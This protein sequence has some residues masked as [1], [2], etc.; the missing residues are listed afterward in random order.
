MQQRTIQINSPPILHHSHAALSAGSLALHLLADLDVDVE[1]LR[2]A[3]I[4]ADGFALVQFALTVI[5][6]NA[7]LGAGLGQTK[8]VSRGSGR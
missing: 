2:N 7:L 5:V 4:Q 6:R 8:P 3:A 1:K